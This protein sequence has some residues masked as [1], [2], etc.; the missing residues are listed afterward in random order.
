MS[1]EDRE[2]ELGQDVD[3]TPTF[4]KVRATYKPPESGTIRKQGRFLTGITDFCVAFA[5]RS[6]ALSSITQHTPLS[7]K[8][9]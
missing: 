3:E 2:A 5:K 4:V 1:A 8:T 6:M 9:P 7:F